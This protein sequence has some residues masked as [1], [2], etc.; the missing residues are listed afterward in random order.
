MK[1]EKHMNKKRRSFLMLAFALIVVVGAALSVWQTGLAS[2]TT[3]G[4]QSTATAG[5]TY[6]TTTVRRGDL[7]IS[8]SGSGQIITAQSAELGFSLEG[9][10]AEL[11]VQ[12]GDTVTKGQVL[13]IL[14]GQDA[15]K[16]KV[17]D[18]R[19]A[20]QVA[21]KTL[22][23]LQSNTAGALAQAQIDQAD[24]EEAY[25]KAEA[26]LHQKGDARCSVSK[27]QEYYFQYIYAQKNVD[28]WEGYLNGHTGY[29]RDYIL[30]QLAPMRKARDIAYANYVYC[31][32]YTDEEIQS[33][34]ASMQVAKA[35]LDQANAVY[36]N[37][38]ANAGVD[39]DAVVVA[40]ATLKK[41]Q[42]QLAK[43]EQDLADATITAPMDGTVM[44]VSASAGQ[45]VETGTV[46]TLANLEQPQV[47]VNIDETDL[48]NFAVGCSAQVIFNSLPSQT[49]D[50]VVTEISP[51]LVTMQSVGMVQGLVDLKDAKQA[52]GNM[53]PLNLA[54]TVEVTCAQAKNA[55]QVPVMALYESAGQPS[56]VYVLNQQGQPEKREVVVGIKTTAFAEIRSGLE[57]GE[58]VI[59]S[60]IQ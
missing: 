15:L 25:I 53:L 52:S 36:E 16:Q 1:E 29:G 31:Q 51:T 41:A 2:R 13:A 7:A 12:V 3:T 54:A 34:Q 32:G 35:Q 11:D 48:E 47:Q 30:Q 20:V 60:P 46:I 45:V 44:E 55:L 26:N 19:L 23:D 28:T 39:E 14:A 18:Q 38:K 37:L 43:A 22:D 8:V 24:A 27:T 58:K 4:Q 5:E 59:T 9:T 42:A 21:Q 17:A 49:F 33:S 40:Q 50:G 10:I 56:Y 6:Q 57:E